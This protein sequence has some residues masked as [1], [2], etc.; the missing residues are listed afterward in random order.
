MAGRAIEQILGYVPLT[1]VIQA[2]KSGIPNLLPPELMR[3]SRDVI[4][5]SGLYTQVT[6]ERRLASLT[7]YGA[8]SNTRD[9][10]ELASKPVKLLHTFE[11]Q[12]IPPLVMQKLRNYDNYDLMRQGKQE[13]ARQYK[14]FGKLFANLRIACVQL[15]L[16]NGIIW[17]KVEGTKQRILPS[18]S[19]NTYTIDFQMAGGNQN[20]IGG[21]ISAAWNVA[22][23]NIPVQLVNLE[24]KAAQ[25]TGYPLRLAIYGANLPTYFTN[26]DYVIDYLARMPEMSVEWLKG[27]GQIPNGLFGFKWI[28]AYT[29]FYERDDGTGTKDAIW[30][31]DQVTFTPDVSGGTDSE[32][33]WEFI[34]GSFLV[35][36]T[37]DVV[38]SVQS[39]DQFKTVYGS[40]G[41]AQMSHDPPGMVNFAGDTFLGVLRNPDAIYQCDTVF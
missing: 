32:D 29:F 19:G 1:G 36:T 3:K 4:G 22:T 30:P 17:V 28:P 14:E 40:F 25:T 6:G 15:V 37:V 41:Y 34:E 13:I 11:K 10:K 9:L 33:W 7:H 5:D 21:T 38:T 39:L 20:Q 27:A 31:A 16:A 18:A 26:N 12:P 24:A 23:T 2:T 35:P 8:P